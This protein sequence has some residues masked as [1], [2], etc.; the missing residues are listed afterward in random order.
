MPEETV[1]TTETP[2][3][4]VTTEQGQETTQTQPT[5]D[6][7]TRVS[8]FQLDNDPKKESVAEGGTFNSQE[9]KDSIAA[10]DNPELKSKMEAMQKSLVS[11]A[12]DKFQEIATLR[13]EMQSVLENKNG[14]WTPDKVQ[15][16][17]QDPKFI[18]AAQQI[19]GTTT[20]EEFSSMSDSEKAQFT[21][22]QT[23]INDLTSKID[24]QTEQQRLTV[25]TQQH[26]ELAKKYADYD[27]SRIDSISYDILQG[28]QQI[29]PEHVYKAFNYDDALNKSYHLGRKD[30]REGVVEKVQSIAAEGTTVSASTEQVVPEKGESNR[31]FWDKIVAKN[32]K[33]AVTKS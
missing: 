29:T 12:N 9:L 23:T 5:D 22:M 8:K 32:L 2:E 21:K 27:S 31:S 20:E 33:Q 13:K 7:L 18:Q 28:K 25:R 15:A 6:L 4:T 10:I 11:G 26:T 3:T 14:E 19:A 16:L 24:T 30:E 17:A 1:A